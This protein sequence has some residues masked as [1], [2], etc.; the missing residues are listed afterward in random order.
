MQRVMSL[1]CGA[2]LIDDRGLLAGGTVGSHD[3]EMYILLKVLL[4]CYVIEHCISVEF[5]QRPSTW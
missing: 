4:K 3:V 2:P 1:N 5:Y